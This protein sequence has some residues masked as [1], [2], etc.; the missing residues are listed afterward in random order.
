M[1]HILSSLRRAAMAQVA[2]EIHVASGGSRILL[3]CY[4]MAYCLH[5]LMFKQISDEATDFFSIQCLRVW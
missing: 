2:L 4:L 3:A 5:H 1:A